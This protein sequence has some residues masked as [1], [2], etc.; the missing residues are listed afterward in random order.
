MTSRTLLVPT[1]GFVSIGAQST[2][3]GENSLANVSG[4]APVSIATRN[5]WFVIRCSFLNLRSAC[6]RCSGGRAIEPVSEDLD[7]R[8]RPIGDRALQ[9]QTVLVVGQQFQA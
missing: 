4:L 3:V 1:M 5:G 9:Q 6:D 8:E 2:T 7:R